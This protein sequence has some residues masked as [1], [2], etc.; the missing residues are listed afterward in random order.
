MAR[1]YAGIF[2]LVAFLTMLARGVIREADP[3]STVFAAW[4]ALVVF[5]MVGYVLGW[6]A[7][8]IVD[9]SVAAKLAAEVKASQQAESSGPPP[10]RS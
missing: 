7:G 10:A 6:I 5:A 3:E 9:E 8:R 1:I 4:C 2:G